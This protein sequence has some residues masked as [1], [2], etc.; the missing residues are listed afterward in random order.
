MRRSKFLK[1]VAVIPFAP[2]AI[3]L[4]KACPFDPIALAKDIEAVIEAAVE[5]IGPSTNCLYAATGEEVIT[6]GWDFLPEHAGVCK[7]SINS[8][9]YL[10]LSMKFDMPGIIKRAIKRGGPNPVT[11]YWRQRPTITRSPEHL[12]YW[13]FSTRFL[14][15]KKIRSFTAFMDTY[16]QIKEETI[17]KLADTGCRVIKG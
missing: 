8:E 6:Y 15:S 2:L 10:P 5:A 17:R 3:P 12:G 4:L 14:V 13:R 11:L 1:S 16:R 7:Y 9:K